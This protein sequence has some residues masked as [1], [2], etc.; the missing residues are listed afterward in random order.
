MRKNFSYFVRPLDGTINYDLTKLENLLIEKNKLIKIKIDSIYY[1]VVNVI[2]FVNLTTKALKE[3]P[4][5]FV[6]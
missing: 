3:D 1:S 6:N 5:F 2:D 4:F